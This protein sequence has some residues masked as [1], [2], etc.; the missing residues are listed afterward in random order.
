MRLL[1]QASPAEP[2]ALIGVYRRRN[3]RHVLALVECA[4]AAGWATAWW[5]LD[6]VP[7]DLA[8]YTVGQGAGEKFPLL[9]E[10][11]DHASLDSGWLV[12][13]DDDVAFVRGSV[14][15]LVQACAVAEL[16]LAQPAQVAIGSPSHEITLSRALS[17]VR[18]TTF[19]EIGPLFVVAPSCRDRIVPFPVRRGMGWGLELE[20]HGLLER[21]CRLGIVDAVTVQHL[22]PIGASYDVELVKKG[23]EAELRARGAAHW[24]DLQETLETWRPWQRTPPWV[25]G[26]RR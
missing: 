24:S 12:V 11:V 21:G 19:V 6:D 17:V 15:R 8:R 10:I 13:A 26:S 4:R 3:A 22:G 14:G 23:S 9:N 20:W 7:G 18:A 16:A 2:V 25:V 1:G 5:A